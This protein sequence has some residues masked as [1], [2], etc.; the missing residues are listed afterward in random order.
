MAKVLSLIHFD[1]ANGS[2]SI[3][4]ATGRTLTPYGNTQISTATAVFG[5]ASCRFDGT[6]DY[7]RLASN[8]AIDLGALPSWRIDC[9]LKIDSLTVRKTLCSGFVS[10]S[11]RW[12]IEL[13]TA[14]SINFYV[15]GGIL[16]LSQSI[17]VG[18]WFH[19][20]IDYDGTDKRVFIDGVLAGTQ[21]G[22]FPALGVGSFDLGWTQHPSFPYAYA[23]N[24]DEFFLV[25][26]VA[27][28]TAGFTPPAVAY[29]LATDMPSG[30]ATVPVEVIVHKMGAASLPIS[31]SVQARGEAGLPISVVVAPFG[32]ASVQV[33]VRVAPMG[34]AQAPISVLVQA[35]GK[36]SLPIHVRIGQVGAA[37]IGLEVAI[38][39]AA[40][41]SGVAS[42]C[43]GVGEAA[44][45]APIVRLDG[46]DITDQT[47]GEIRVDAEEGAAR[48]ADVTIKPETGATLQLM[49]WTG[50]ALTIDVADNRIGTPRWPMRLF[51]G[52][53]DTPSLDLESGVIALTATD[54]LQG[55][56]DGMSAE[57][58]AAVIGGYYSPVVF[59]AAAKGWSIAQDRLSTVPASLDISPLGALRLTPWAPKSTPDLTLSDLIGNGS[60]SVDL[61]DRRSL[62]NEVNVTFAYRF[63]RIK[64]EGH[65]VSFDAVT[66]T[67]F[68]QY[69]L[70]GNAFMQRAQVEAAISSAG[71]TL[72]DID[73]TPLPDEL[74]PV[75]SGFFTPSAADA[76]L[77]MGFAAT[78]SFDYVAT[79]EEQHEIRVYAQKSID[80]VG[81]RRESMS[82]ALQGEYPDIVATETALKL[83]KDDLTS[84]PPADMATVVLGKTTS[85]EATLTPETDRAAA[86]VA[87]E[88]L[89]AI[90]KARIWA[91]HRGNGVSATV[92]LIPA[93]DVDK[94]VAISHNGVDVQG[95]V[96]RVVHRLSLDDGMAVTDFSVAVCSVSGVGIVH[97]EDATTAPGSTE[98]VATDIDLSPTVV[99]NGGPSEDLA[100]TITFP[101]VEEAERNGSAVV[102]PSS[103]A[104]KLVED[105]FTV[106]I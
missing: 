7:L 81:L 3:V 65:G 52:I 16:D 23:G 60:L 87:M 49:G 105:V 45:W 72:M 19:L 76:D 83:Y 58:L 68:A 86:N 48:V 106:T 55:R 90:A 13:F 57:A 10:T 67:T 34:K 104:A 46:V 59:D 33:S 64:A 80:A 40:I 85:T 21:A 91:S 84:I 93:L 89:I 44:I 98:A 94:T 77:C 100:I 99:F 9:R 15:G 36:A 31:V 27:P 95:K 78:V 30:V 24:I 47:I 66:M 43:I 75:G 38:V 39:P 37:S 51:T 54:D 74:I 18:A 2:T 5:S 103:Y 61:A 28:T 35:L 20:R 1:G 101:A 97:D 29:T 63:P 4:D 50:R 88:T 42:V 69:I 73:Y 11:S 102:L 41:L 32:Q 14:T 82:G 62:T 96:R 79:I 70:D 22:N 25:T 17:P 26:G 8:G 12:S 56:C 92:P 53:V 71:G 6:G